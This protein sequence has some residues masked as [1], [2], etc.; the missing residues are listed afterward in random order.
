MSGAAAPHKRPNWVRMGLYVFTTSLAILGAIKAFQDQLGAAS[1]LMMASVAAMILTKLDEIEYF[2]GLGIE[3]KMRTLK[4]TVNE[5]H[6]VVGQLQA[7]A[8]STA[9]H[10]ITL[11][12]SEE[13]YLKM[14]SR[15]TAWEMVQHVRQ[16]LED[17]KISQDQI[18]DVLA[19][20]HRNVCAQFQTSFR[21]LA[22]NGALNVLIFNAG[23]KDAQAV[24]TVL[25]E[26]SEACTDPVQWQRVAIVVAE[27]IHSAPSEI[28]ATLQEILDSVVDLEHWN[29]TRQLRRPQAY[30]S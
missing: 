5:A 11:V 6:E 12:S 30:F 26:A 20:F 4:E 7:L 21:Q 29:A 9:R 25:T 17:L 3:A 15:R 23:N 2:K 14:Y 24:S 22:S 13:G 16:S 19:P 10:I 1:L 18:E 28:S 27:Y 8:V